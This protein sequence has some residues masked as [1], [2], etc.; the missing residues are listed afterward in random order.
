MHKNLNLIILQI[1]TYMDAEES[2]S[3]TSFYLVDF[4]GE[5]PKITEL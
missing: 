3:G 1:S 5:E 2:I 4:S